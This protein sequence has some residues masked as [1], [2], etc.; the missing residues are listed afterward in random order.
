MNRQSLKKLFHHVASPQICE[1][2]T[3]FHL[4]PS[5]FFFFSHSS[6]III[7]LCHHGESLEHWEVQ[8]SL[9]FENGWKMMTTGGS[10]ED[11]IIV[12]IESGVDK[13]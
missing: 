9:E 1:G 4:R 6:L 10:Q 7:S 11:F 12:V 13:K 8:L 3:T 2:C 5:T